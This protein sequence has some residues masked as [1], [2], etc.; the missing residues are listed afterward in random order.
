MPQVNKNLN[1]DME[2]SASSLEKALIASEIRY[3]RLFESAK[4][5]ILILDAELGM[6][7]DVNPFL[8]NLLGYS[9][10][11]LIQKAVW[12][13]GFFKDIIQNQEKFLELQHNEYV[14]YED[15][16]LETI[17]GQKIHVEFVSNV[18]LE[19][20][21]KVI[22][23]NIRDITA[24]KKME[25]D[26]YESEEKFRIITENSA[27]AIFIADKEG[28]YLYVNKQAINLL[29][30]SKEEMLKF[31]IADIS[32]ANKVEEYF[33]IFQRLFAEGSSYSEIE[34]VKKDGSNVPTDLNA[35]LLP[36]GLV[37]GSCRDI[38][39]RKRAE[40][41]VRES[42]ERYRSV[43]QSAK[44]AIVT[45]NNIG[46]VTAWNRGAEKI[47]G[48]TAME[49]IGEK[50][51]KIIPQTFHDRHNNGIRRI[52]QGGAHHVIGKTVEVVGLHKNGTEFPL[53][54]SLSLWEKSSKRLFTGIIRDITERKEVEKTI[55]NLAKFPSEN[56]DPVLRI[57]K[58]GRLLFA[59]ESSY[60]FFTWK[61]ET[62]KPAP[63][64]LQNVGSDIFKQKKIRNIEFSHHK[65]LFSVHAVPIPESGYTNLY[66]RDITESN[67]NEKE[68]TM[69]AHALKSIKECLSITDLG[70]NIIFV[71]DSFL[72][73]Y[74]YRKNEIIGKNINIV[75]SKNNPEK[76]VQK[77]LPA[78]L[79]GGWKG[80]LLNKG[81]NGSE[82]PIYLSTTIIKD[83]N[84]K[85]LGLIGV[86]SDITEQK[87]IENELINAKEKAEESDRLKSAFLANMSHEIR[88]PM[89]GILGFIGL[90]KEPKLSGE[91]QQEFIDIIEKSGARMLNTIND[92]I[93]ISRIESGQ[94]EISISE[95][96]INT[97]D[98]VHFQFL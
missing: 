1:S 66:I 69:L 79:K 41:E 32:P 44:D 93:N 59:N 38:T 29:G 65:R 60:S 63:A 31:T 98:G 19:G 27:D 82:F 88:T 10:E 74:G 28:K 2:K 86:A 95:T 16:P 3:R 48:Y 53:E 37:Y 25:K 71:N 45:A 55:N 62:G 80:E 43:V 15:L 20:N 83:K 40:E 9:K 35:V 67:R 36:N 50:L 21:K 76:L 6:I 8:I 73:T 57:S 52:E 64:I 5:G 78:T 49:I 81:K 90:L 47:F 77:I 85:P 30:Y 72:K 7:V 75:R 91:K 56:P 54:L 58:D 92:I 70:D 51:E 84:G 94:V 97:A 18:Y 89:N 22:Q 11:N 26:L 14:R 39:K 12:E 46:L 68:I 42:E 87:R 13:I 61:L 4:D 17:D 23:C 34:L 96:N 24:R 33:Q